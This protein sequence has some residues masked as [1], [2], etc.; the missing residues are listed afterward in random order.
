MLDTR[1]NCMDNDVPQLKPSRLDTIR[2][3]ATAG[4]TVA[5]VAIPQ[6]MGYALLAG[7]PPTYGLYTTIVVGIVAALIGSCTHLVSG[8]NISTATIVPL[9][10]LPLAEEF[11]QEWQQLALL[12][13]LM[14]GVAQLI[15]WALRLTQLVSFI[16]RAVIVGFTSGAGV[17][18]AINQLKYLFEIQIDRHAFLGFTVT[19]VISHLGNAHWIAVLTG[20][21]TAALIIGMKK[22]SPRLP[23]ALISLVVVTGGCYL[24][25]HAGTGLSL[26]TIRDVGGSGDAAGHIPRA[27]PGLQLFP[28]SL[29]RIG[30]LA[31]GAVAIALL[32]MIETASIAKALASRSGQR[33]D[34]GRDFLAQGVSKVVGA[35]FQCMPSSA[36]FARSEVLYKSGAQTRLGGVMAGVAVA[37]IILAAAPLAEQVPLAGIAGMLIYYGL[38]M[39]DI[40]RIRAIVRVGGDDAIVLFLTMFATLTIPLQYAVYVGIIASVVLFLRQAQQVHIR[41]MVRNEEGTFAEIPIDD[42]T[43][44][45]AVVFLQI[46]GNLF[47]A[48]ADLFEQR[49]DTLRQNNPRVV[50]VRLRRTLSIDAT[51]IETFR[52]FVR[53]MREQGGTVIVCGVTADIRSLLERSGL[54]EDLGEEN[55]F[56]RN[57]QVFG[58]ARLAVERALTLVRQEDQRSEAQRL[59][60]TGGSQSWFYRI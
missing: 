28:I 4:L 42:Y 16:S 12:L 35:F 11:S 6:A 5:L 10:L 34:V 2:G 9:I 55:V 25:E 17:V 56:D 51:I 22:L 47:F 20:A 37:V 45:A 40:R 3:D 57:Q 54:L 23:A 33:I 15:A 36:S 44:R 49:L 24:L 53:D 21:V 18:I 31:A 60:R 32:G 30:D 8:A 26:I 19:D 50:I 1:K 52:R 58:S 59:L 46:E 48:Q 39:V 27:L 43:G 29:D 38:R 41:E 13:C 14:V 7:L